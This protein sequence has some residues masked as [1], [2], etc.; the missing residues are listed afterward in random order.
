MQSLELL[1]CQE[2][3]T[4]SI[5]AHH[6][7]LGLDSSIESVKHISAVITAEGTQQN[8]L[9]EDASTALNLTQNGIRN[10]R[11]S[12]S[13][14]DQFHDNAIDVYCDQSAPETLKRGREAYVGSI[15]WRSW[16]GQRATHAQLLNFSQWNTHNITRLQNDP[17]VMSAI[18]GGKTQYKENLSAAVV[19]G[20]L[21]PEALKSA[22]GVDGTKVYIGDLF[23]TYCKDRAGYHVPGSSWV[24]IAGERT[25][26]N[27][28]QGTIRNIRGLLGHELNHA[29]LGQFAHRWLNEAVTEHVAESLKYGQENILSPDRRRKPSGVYDHER[30]LLDTVLSRGKYK[31]PI[32]EVT[33]VYSEQ[34]RDSTQQLYK[35]VDDSWSDVL[36]EGE[37]M[38]D[39]IE[40]YI[41]QRTK[42]MIKRGMRKSEAQDI[43]VEVASYRLRHGDIDTIIEG[44][45]DTSR[46][47]TFFTSSSS[48]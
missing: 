29:V 17:E 28:N 19:N 20:W 43:A 16:L 48:K 45:R 15:S 40:S 2:E 47:P 36:P 44:A 34:S 38:I 7:T 42:S 33:R 9:Q 41:T 8:A 3:V 11:K 37:L 18:E 46:K 24:M 1:R 4:V 26:G 10:V 39:L 13:K 31:I 12:L 30:E 27:Y 32:T 14:I 21:H 6:A 23:D 22:R 35:E 5:R 25:N